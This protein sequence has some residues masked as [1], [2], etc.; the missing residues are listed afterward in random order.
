[1]LY[2]AADSGMRPQEYIVLPHTNLTP[3]GVKV[4]RALET[5]GR[6]IA[7]TKTPAGRRFIPLSPHVLEM[8]N[9]YRK[10]HPTPSP[11]NLIFPT[12]SGH[13]QSPDN[14]RARG[15]YYVCEQAGLME[16]VDEDARMVERPKYSPFNADRAKCKS[17]M[18]PEAH[19]ARKD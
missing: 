16:M 2:L 19:G 4:D 18:C 14:W 11:Y 13:W 1:M 15:F 10:E 9:H 6:K 7:T 3:D 12:A 8:I 17:Q 5:G